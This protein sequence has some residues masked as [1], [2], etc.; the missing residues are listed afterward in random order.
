[1]L[2]RVVGLRGGVTMIQNQQ[3]FAMVLILPTVFGTCSL[4]EFVKLCC[5]P[6]HCADTLTHQVAV[7]GVRGV[8]LR[9]AF[10][11]T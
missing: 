9:V 2:R 3:T 11:C 10:A 1:M 5:G 6:R 4:N 7:E 8:D